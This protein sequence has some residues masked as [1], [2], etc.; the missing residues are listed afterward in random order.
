MALF[1]HIY[2]RA[3][4]I[5]QTWFQSH[6]AHNEVYL[7]LLFLL[8]ET[9]RDAEICCELDRLTHSEHLHE[10][11]ILGHITRY[12]SVSLK[13]QEKHYHSSWNADVK[14]TNWENNILEWTQH[15]LTF[16]C[17]LRLHGPVVEKIKTD[18]ELNRFSGTKLNW[19]LKL[20]YSFE[21][22]T[23]SVSESLLWLLAMVLAIAWTFLKE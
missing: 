13:K 23:S 11:V 9:A 14:S 22:M 17:V 8:G 19:K 20:E 5:V 4:A 21:Y 15:S 10:T 3:Y 2:V 7:L 16:H 1:E 18:H 6:L 12:Q